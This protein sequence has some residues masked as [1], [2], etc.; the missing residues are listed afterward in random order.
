MKISLFTPHPSLLFLLILPPCFSSSSYSASNS[1]LSFGFLCYRQFLKPWSQKQ[2]N[3][4]DGEKS[5]C[6]YSTVTGQQGKMQ[7]HIQ[8]PSEVPTRDTNIQATTQEIR[9][10]TWMGLAT[11]LSK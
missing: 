5:H 7:G 6:N 10:G 8:S 3:S 1:L 2:Y 4:S 11:Q 9:K